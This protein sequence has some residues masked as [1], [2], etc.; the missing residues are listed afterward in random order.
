[1][2]VPLFRLTLALA[3]AA[4]ALALTALVMVER[5]L[6]VGPQAPVHELDALGRTIVYPT[7]N[8]SALI[9]LA[10]AALGL[11]TLLRALRSVAHQAVAQRALSRSLKA[12]R[13]RE[14]GDV[15]VIR[16]DAP[17]AM[18]AGLRRPRI[19][20]T[21]AALDV[22][23][24]R[25]L[26]AV[27][28]HEAHH[29]ARRDPLRLAIAQVLGDALPPVR[30]LAREHALATEIDADAAALRSAGGDAAPLASAM[31]R[32]AKAPDGAVGIEAG[33]VDSLLGRPPGR[34]LSLCTALGV[35]TALVLLVLV[36]FLAGRTAASSATLALPVLSR[37]PCIV[38][39]ALLPGTLAALAASFLRRRTDT[40]HV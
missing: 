38:A 14:A 35:L 3:T 27:L 5:S 6:T 1:M 10:L 37:Q 17:R 31:L 23:P 4:L 28:A 33:R 32:L 11:L 29:R 15:I 8:P 16:G 40:V 26:E 34:A 39:L 7:A 19:Y 22:L 21:E 18:C 13:V 9:V 25:E 20:V 36:A 30:R 24:P 2:G 12:C